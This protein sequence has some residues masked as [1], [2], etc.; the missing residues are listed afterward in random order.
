[1][2]CKRHWDRMTQ[3]KVLPRTLVLG[4]LK[5]HRENVLFEREQ[6][7]MPQ[8]QPDVVF[9]RVQREVRRF[10]EAKGAFSAARLKAA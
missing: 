2:A 3:L 4:P 6:G 5:T 8:T 1:M 10:C 7:L 9:Y